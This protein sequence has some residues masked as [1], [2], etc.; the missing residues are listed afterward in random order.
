MRKTWT[1]GKERRKNRT[2][3]Q[4]TAVHFPIEEAELLAWAEQQG[5]ANL[6]DFIRQALKS[7]RY[8]L[9][10]YGPEWRERI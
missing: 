1:T 2:G 10:K 8:L 3:G 7:H 6:S 4:S 5:R 9:E